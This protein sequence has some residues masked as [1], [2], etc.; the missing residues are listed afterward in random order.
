MTLDRAVD[1]GGIAIAHMR[2]QERES[3]VADR[4]Q[5]LFA[6]DLTHAFIH[7]L[8]DYGRWPGKVVAATARSR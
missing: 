3:H 2:V 1:G 7:A 8:G 6:V 4:R 5:S